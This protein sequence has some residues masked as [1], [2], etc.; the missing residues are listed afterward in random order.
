MSGLWLLLITIVS[1]VGAIASAAITVLHSRNDKADRDDISDAVDD[2]I[3]EYRRL[4]TEP[5]REENKR[6]RKELA[7]R[8]KR[9]AP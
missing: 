9:P 3:E 5:L 2:A 7:D 6:L 1:T 4:F 8:R